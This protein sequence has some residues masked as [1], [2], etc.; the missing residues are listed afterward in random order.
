MPRSLIHVF[1]LAIGILTMMAS[2]NTEAAD[3]QKADE[4][5]GA[6]RQAFGTGDF[7][8]AT[9]LV[10]EALAADPN[11]PRAYY[12]RGAIQEVQKKHAAAIADFTKVLQLD[13][14]AVDVYND[15]GAAQFKLGNFKESIADFDKYLAVHPDRAPD[16]WQRGISYYYA[17]RFEDGR[18]QF[19]LHQTVNSNDVEN[20]VWHFLCTTRELGL[21]EARKRLIPIK[22]DGRVPM[23]QI[24][25]LFGGKGTADDVM[26][27]AQKG[28]T[29][30]DEQKIQL[31]YAHLYLGLYYEAIGEKEKA[32]QHIVMADEKYPISHYMWDVAH[33]HAPL[34]KKG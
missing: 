28:E 26:A 20:A 31:F 7:D 27:A 21:E 9:K 25:A 33:V 19:E 29:G 32:R 17:G 2:T 12:A 10:S 6:A 5:L 13:P 34:F 14:Q 24:Y 16:H 1:S 3:A 4:L 15:R 8:R 23:M 18:K 11:N 22:G 30:S